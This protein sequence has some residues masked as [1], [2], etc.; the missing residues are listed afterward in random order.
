MA[1]WSVLQRMPSV[2]GDPAPCPRQI[3]FGLAGKG[4]WHA[5]DKLRA[6][7]PRKGFA[8]VQLGLIVTVKYFGRYKAGYIRDGVLLSV[9]AVH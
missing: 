8:P 1:M 3:R 5:L 7:P 6:G 4:L 9:V 2:P